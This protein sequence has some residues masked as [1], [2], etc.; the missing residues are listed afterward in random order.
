LVRRL[1]TLLSAKRVE[2]RRLQ[3]IVM[4]LLVYT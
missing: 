4:Q 2:A 1:L 3:L